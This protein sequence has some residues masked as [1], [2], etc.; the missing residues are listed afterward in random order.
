MDSGIASLSGAVAWRVIPN[1]SLWNLRELIYAYIPLG[2]LFISPGRA[3]GIQD[4]L[5]SPWT[6]SPSWWT[7]LSFRELFFFGGR[8]LRVVLLGE[9][10]H[11]LFHYDEVRCLM[12]SILNRSRFFEGYPL[13]SGAI[14]WASDSESLFVEPSGVL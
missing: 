8:L 6:S 3:V 12:K 2:R 9:D 7:Y 11:L 4:E 5:C 13:P 14:A 1:R 10:F